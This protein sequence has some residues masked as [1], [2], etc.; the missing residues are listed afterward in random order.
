MG[1][2]RAGIDRVGV[3]TGGEDSTLRGVTAYRGHL[4]MLTVA[5]DSSHCPISDA[6]WDIYGRPRLLPTLPPLSDGSKPSLGT[7]TGHM[8]CRGPP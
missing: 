3:H 7:Q 8:L 2:C 4:K 6:G 1:L 5:C